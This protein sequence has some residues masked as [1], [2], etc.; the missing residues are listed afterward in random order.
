M[1]YKNWII[2]GALIGALLVAGI[3]AVAIGPEGGNHPSHTRQLQITELCARNETVIADNS[4]KYRDYVELYAPDQAV[5]LAGYTLSNGQV[6]SPALGDITLEAGE[7]RVFFLGDGITGFSLSASRGETLTLKAP[8]GTVA[9]QVT[10]RAMGEDQVMVLQGGRYEL[11]SQPSP[12]FANNAQGQA[13]FRQGWVQEDPQ[14]VI[15]EVLLDNERSLPDELGVFSDVIELQNIGQTPVNLG[16]YHLSDRESDRFAYRLPDITLEPGAWITIYCDGENYISSQG[17]IHANF[18]LSRGETLYLTDGAGGYLEAACQ[19]AG[20][21]ISWQLSDGGEFLPG[22]P[23]LGFSNDFAGVQQALAARTNYESELVISEVMLAACGSSHNGRVGDFVEITNR[24]REP[25]STAGWYLSDNGDPY[26]YP[27]PETLLQPGESLVISCHET[28]TGFGLS[29]GET[30]LLTGPDFRYA[31]GALCTLSQPGLTMQ[32]SSGDGDQPWYFDAPTLGYANTQQGRQEYLAEQKPQTLRISEVMCANKSYLPGPYGDTCDWIELYN[33]GSRAVNLKDYALSDDSDALEQCPLPELT[34]APGEYVVLMAS[35]AD[36]PVRKGYGVIPLNLSAQG[37]SLYLSRQGVVEDCAI[38]PAVAGDVSYGRGKGSL[39][40]SLLAAVTPGSA[41]GGSAQ[42]SQAPVALTAPGTY[43]DVESLQITLSGPG[44]LYYTTGCTI[45]DRNSTPYTGPITITSTTI[46][47]VVCYEEGKDASAV[48]DFSY[49]LNENDYLP[50]ISLV[51]EPENLWGYTTGIYADGPNISSE[52]PYLG[53]NFWQDWERPCSITLFETQGTAAFTANCGLK[54]FGAYSRSNEKKSFACMFR[55]QYGEGELS[56]PVF[57]EDSLPYYE[58]LVLRAG[59]QDA[60]YANMRDEVITSLAG[61]YLGLPVQAYRP[62]VLYLNGEYWG[63]Y[64]IREKLNDQYVAGHYAMQAEDVYMCQVSQSGYPDYASLIN[65]VYSHDLSR[66]EC[67]D[68]VASRVDIQNYTDYM[69][70]QMWI[71]NTDSSNVKFFQ[72]PEGKWTWAFYDTDMSFFTAAANTIA[73]NLD[74]QQEDVICRTL[75]VR[76]LKNEAYRDYFLER[77]AWQVSNVWT[78]E[79]I[80]RRIDELSGLI[81]E[82]MKKDC[83]RWNRR[84]SY[85]QGQVETMRS[86]AEKRSGYFMTYAR[87]YFHLSQAQMQEY[88]FPASD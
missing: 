7:Y 25:V 10:T 87:R 21:D 5:S 63:V 55:S 24:S 49:I 65:Y 22:T 57:G 48:A 31:P 15:S 1:K 52:K 16:R 61:E 38:I 68:Y 71:N 17:H 47:R 70:A 19:N 40:F 66:Q 41:N 79:N 11:S 85:W 44:Q 27:L 42:P 45:P 67:Y 14:V 77:M 29:Q 9:A 26:K 37:E 2:A 50:V 6:T 86:Y 76:L 28:V 33:A 36:T 13:A 74:T 12:N 80:N 54:I 56:Y 30:L 69:I 23:S 81:G 84:Y 53:A 72:N 18:A 34:L 32:R 75:L 39:E 46:L 88:G 4:G 58:S 83:A 43:D 82:D 51:T 62:V 8:D 20:E 60:Y 59:G 64:Y 35:T 3:L 78:Q 73:K